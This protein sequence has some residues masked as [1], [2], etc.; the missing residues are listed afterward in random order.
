M[1]G[2][3][4]SL[5]FL[6]HILACFFFIRPVRN[7][8]TR[9]CLTLIPCLVL[10]FIGCSSLPYLEMGSVI[11]I[12]L[13]WMIN[14]RLFH[15]IVM[16]PNETMTLSSYAW[17]FV[18]LM[19][20]IIPSKSERPIPYDFGVAAIK[21]FVSH[22]ISRWLLT[23][24]GSDSYLRIIMFFVSV[25][26][27]TFFTEFQMGIVRLLTR[28]KYT[29]LEFTHYPF[30]SE[31]VR[32]FWSRRY[33]LLISTL[34]KESIFIPT[35]RTL[36]V[37]TTVAAL[38]SFI[39]SGILHGHVA[40]SAFGASTPLPAFFF[41][42]LHGLAC[43]VEVSFPFSVPRPLKIA[44]TQVFIVATAPLYL[45]L[46]TRVTPQFMSLNKPMLFEVDW[47]PK[48]PIPSFC[49]K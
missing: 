33:N 25:C 17:K 32:E 35:R 34:L 1:D 13:C 5:A 47:I 42:F 23:C 3:L 10:T 39:V 20:P 6:V 29:V 44:L 48:L 24:S 41:F 19:L 21:F 26:A 45:G 8:S 15:L 12:S 4:I 27:G 43:C 38:L 7:I 31:S 22:W 46:F 49:P 40:V 14:I 18:W 11:R 9:S 2:R 36:C 16:L 37:S 30:F 28:N